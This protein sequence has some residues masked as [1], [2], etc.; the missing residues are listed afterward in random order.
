MAISTY[1]ELKTAI[2]DWTHRTDLTSVIPTFIT[3]AEARISGALRVREMET[4]SVIP[5]VAN[6]AYIDL[7]TDYRSMKSLSIDGYAPLNL[8]P[9]DTFLALA[10]SVMVGVP[11]NYL[12]Q[13]PRIRLWPIPDGVYDVNLIY[14]ANIPTLSD[15]APTN[16]LLT[17]APDIYLWGS[18]LENAIYSNDQELVELYSARFNESVE[19]TWNSFNL[20]SFSGSPLRAVSDYVV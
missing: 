8:L 4:L 13:G 11:Q 20:E 2:A 9:D 12:V 7:P 10:A 15:A 16:W 19:R 14:Y 5:T 3:L 17:K 18:L 6:N 1:S